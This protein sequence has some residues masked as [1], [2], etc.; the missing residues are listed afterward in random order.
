MGSSPVRPR[1][2]KLV[3]DRADIGGAIMCTRN[4]PAAQV[5]SRI[6]GGVGEPY[7]WAAAPPLSLRP[8]LTAPL[9]HADVAAAAGATL[10]VLGAPFRCPSHQGAGVDAAVQVAEVTGAL[11]ALGPVGESSHYLT[12]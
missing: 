6:F 10:R 12:L 2:I 9:A 11:A 7:R 4:A 8:V 3:F 5:F 1:Y